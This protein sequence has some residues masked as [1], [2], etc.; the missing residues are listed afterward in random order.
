MSSS[1]S[2]ASGG[3]NS[4]SESESRIRRS[5][6]GAL[7]FRRISDA[8][9]SLGTKSSSGSLSS[10]SESSAYE[11]SFRRRLERAS[12]SGA[13]T[14]DDT[15]GPVTIPCWLPCAR[16][17]GEGVSCVMGWTESCEGGE[18]VVDFC[19]VVDSMIFAPATAPPPTPTSPTPTSP[20][21]PTAPTAPTSPSAPTLSTSMATSSPAFCTGFGSFGLEKND[22]NEVCIR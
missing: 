16:R 13:T 17:S 11:I 15:P 2:S 10:P 12:D 14:R 18:K 22:V 7:L 9:L 4:S 6:R 21:V 5:L 20:T 19:V 3:T 8:S 1:S